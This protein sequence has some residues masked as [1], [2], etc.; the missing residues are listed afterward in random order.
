M[1]LTKNWPDQEKILWVMTSIHSY[2][3]SIEQILDRA[4][5][6][7]FASQELAEI[8]STADKHE[9]RL[10]AASSPQELMDVLKEVFTQIE[11]A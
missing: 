2:D 11:E 5:K 1:T 9:A 10:S 6:L 4:L 7:W 8:V 3:K